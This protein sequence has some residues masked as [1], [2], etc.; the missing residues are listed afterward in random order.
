[1]ARLRRAEPARNSVNSAVLDALPHADIQTV[2]FFKRDELTTDLICCDIEI[3]GRVWFFHEEV[4]GWRLLLQHLQQLPGF[5]LDWYA[6]V[7]QPPFANSETVAFRRDR[8]EAS[9][10]RG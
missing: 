6:R 1:M 5:D 7:S 10:Y 8:S 9:P 2:V 3:G 4:E